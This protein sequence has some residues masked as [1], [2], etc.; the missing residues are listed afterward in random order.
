MTEPSPHSGFACRDGKE[1]LVFGERPDGSIVHI[2][3]VSRGLA[4]DCKCPSCGTPLVAR[5]RDMKHH[6]GHYGA[7]DDRP[8]K[9]GLETAVHKFAK[10]ILARRLQLFLPTLDLSDGQDR[11]VGFEGRNYTFDSAILESRLGNIIPDVIVR[12]GNRDLLV[13]FA[14]THECGPEKVAQIREMDLS[15]IEIDLSALNHEVETRQEL[16][17]AILD[18]APRKWLHNPKLRDGQVALDALRQQRAEQFGR[19][20][21][22]LRAAYKKSCSEVNGAVFAYPAVAR[23]EED[24]L[25]RAIRIAVPGYGCF[26]VPSQDWQATILAGMVDLAVD[27]RRAFVSVKA[28]LRKIRDRGWIHPRF[29]RITEEEA[30]AL[31][32]DGTAFARP[33]DAI[34]SWIVTLAKAGILVPASDGQQWMLNRLV[35]SEV[36]NAR[37]RR[38]LPT[39]RI[40][41]IRSAVKDL[42]EK[43]PMEETK[44]FSFGDW[45]SRRLPGKEYTVAQAVRFDDR[46]FSQFEAEFDKLTSRFWSNSLLGPETL[47]LPLDG[48]LARLKEA[49]RQKQEAYE[50]GRQIRLREQAEHRSQELQQHVSDVLGPDWSEWPSI[51]NPDLDGITPANLAKENQDGFLKAARLASDIARRNQQEIRASQT[52]ELARQAVRKEA[53]KVHTGR[54]LDLYLNTA[55]PALG[56]KSPSEYCV[57]EISMKRC[58]EL[59]LPVK[60][61]R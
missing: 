22:A 42:V 21:A 47:G 20:I 53:S 39:I 38:A 49:E 28:A 54:L 59:T 11:W 33:S 13:E 15:A 5:K 51:P 9:T 26:T 6:F 60:K 10:G 27:G 25:A 44:S 7:A 23:I 1:S 29:S 4:C 61:R 34:Q 40:D 31:C 17:R 32:Q 57:D 36:Q 2:S 16:E 12:K 48:H 46:K 37:Y 18:K 19:R 14:V 50:L 30:E 52:A 43:L 41:K 3:E 55:H 8:C 35:A 24:D 56:R 45:A 58:I